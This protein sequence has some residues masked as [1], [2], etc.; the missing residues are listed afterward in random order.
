[1]L[2]NVSTYFDAFWILILAFEAFLCCLATF[3]GFQNVQLKSSLF[4][5]SKEIV[6]ILLRDFGVSQIRLG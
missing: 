1:M 2:T 5:S 4:Y 3:K 6:D